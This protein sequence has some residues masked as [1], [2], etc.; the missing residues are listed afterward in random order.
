M[1]QLRKHV[2]LHICTLLDIPGL[3]R[4]NIDMAFWG[5]NCA[6][7]VFTACVAQAAP[8]KL[9]SI[10]EEGSPA[11]LTTYGGIRLKDC[12]LTAWAPQTARWP[13]DAALGLLPAMCPVGF[14]QPQ[15]LSQSLRYLLQSAT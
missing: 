10:L 9:S 14:R 5:A 15:V 4:H 13:P 3:A 6:Q 11:G 2:E 8:S 1:N 12:W 7:P